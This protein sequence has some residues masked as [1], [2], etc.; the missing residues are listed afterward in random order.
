MA[1]PSLVRKIDKTYFAI[2]GSAAEVVA[3]D[4]QYSTLQSAVNAASSGQKI[5]VLSG[6]H[7]ENVTVDKR[8]TI[9]GQGHATYLDGTLTF[10][11]G[12]DYSLLRGLK[13]GGNLTLNA[14]ADGIFITETWLGS[15]A[16]LTNSGAGN[17]LNIIQE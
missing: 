12:S 13:I 6:T 11:S 16:T 15:S 17:S 14:G 5:V 9:E 3:G 1:N 10:A 2:V 7:T 4:A 8:L